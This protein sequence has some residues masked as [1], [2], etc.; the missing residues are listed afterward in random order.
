MSQLVGRHIVRQ[1][2]VQRLSTGQFCSGEQLATELGLSRTA[3]WKHI[4]SLRTCGLVID[5]VRGKG[6]RM[7]SGIELL[8]RERI[9]AAI[10][11][12]S[13][14][15][16][17]DLLLFPTL[18]STNDYLLQ[19][20]GSSLRQVVIAEQQTAGRG[21]QGRPWLAPF[22]SIT[23]SLSWRFQRSAAAMSGL[24]LALAI[25]VIRAI[26]AGC[27]SLGND[28][29]VS[30]KWPNDIVVADKKLA[31]ILVEM[32][33]EAHGPVDIVMGVGVNVNLPSDI[34]QR[35]NQP[36]TDIKTVFARVP[37]RNQ[38]A[39]D[40]ISEMVETCQHFDEYGFSVFKESW[41]KR[42]Q[43]CNK[44]VALRLG[45]NLHKGI[46]QGVDETGALLLLQGDTVRAFHSGELELGKIKHSHF[47]S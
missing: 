7:T 42:D 14:D 37:S 39:A 11:A 16:L 28:A 5:A 3:V 44:P 13:R 19:H 20:T 17:D 33:G 35:I 43:S 36:A 24:T 12:K 38:L 6:Y 9:N 21:R 22:G 2:L 18:K 4:A 1:Q 32:H 27:A 23:L 29:G 31:G 34:Q 47:Q 8:D 26:E 15:L 10:S 41:S 45:E 25:A 30:V 40:L 46:S